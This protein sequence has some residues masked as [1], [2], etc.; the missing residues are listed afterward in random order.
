[1]VTARFFCYF[2]ALMPFFFGCRCCGWSK[3]V[4]WMDGD[5]DGGGDGRLLWSSGRM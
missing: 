4:G 2:D 1:M 5:G 3:V